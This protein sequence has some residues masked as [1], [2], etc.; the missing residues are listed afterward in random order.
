M[1]DQELL[2]QARAVDKILSENPGATIEVDPDL[3]EFMG[4]FVED[5]ITEED[6]RE[7]GFITDAD[8]FLGSEG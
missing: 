3:A 5:A 7:S 2:E 4:A 8:M 6:M 1:T